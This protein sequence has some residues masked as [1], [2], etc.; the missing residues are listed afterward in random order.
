MFGKEQL[1]RRGQSCQ[2]GRLAFMEKKECSLGSP[3]TKL[4]HLHPE[5]SDAKHNKQNRLSPTLL[6]SRTPGLH[7][8]FHRTCFAIIT[9]SIYPGTTARTVF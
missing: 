4:E 9:N 3:P 2:L 7:N 8:G 6:G 5:Q 1:E